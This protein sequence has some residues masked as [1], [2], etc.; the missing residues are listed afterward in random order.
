MRGRREICSSSSGSASRSN[1]CSGSSAQW[2]ISTCPRASPPA[3][4]R[5]FGGI[6]HRHRRGARR[7]PSM[8]NQAFAVGPGHHLVHVDTPAA[9]RASGSRDCR[10]GLVNQ[11]RLAP[12]RRDHQRHPRR[13]L[14]EAHLEPQ[15]PL[16]QHVAVVGDEDDD[17][18]L[19]GASSASRISADLVVEI[20]DV[21]EIGAAG[22][23]DVILG[24]VVAA[25]VIGVEDALRMRV[26]IGIGDRGTRRAAVLAV[27]V[28]IP[29]LRRAT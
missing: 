18:L 14:E 22:P 3:A 20:G 25:P 8:G 10:D 16:A 4:L 13:A 6:F 26:V 23:G 15:P 2:C 19:P 17:G 12:G 1:N 5:A 7:P 28:E 9:R 11:A 29:E 24:D 27:L 21:G